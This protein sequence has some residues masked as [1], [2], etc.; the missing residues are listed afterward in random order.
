MKT[1]IITVLIVCTTVVLSGCAMYER[2]VTKVKGWVGLD[3]YTVTVTNVTSNVYLTQIL[4]VGHE[5]ESYDI[6]AI[7]NPASVELQ[8]AAE[9][10]DI[11][12]ISAM[13]S[14][15]ADIVIDP[16]EGLLGPGESVE[17][18]IDGDATHLSLVAMIL[19]TNDGFIAL[20]AVD[21]R[22]GEFEL[23]ALDAGT[24]G[25]DEAITGGGAPNTPGIPA[26]PSGKADTSAPGI[27]GVVAEETVSRH[28]GIKGGEGS[29]LS[30]ENHGWSGPVAIVAIAS[31]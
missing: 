26:D 19:P 4:A 21:I 23:E 3:D 5:G 17:F 18:E 31:D 2:S 7:G 27:A 6:Y 8:A 12:G 13:F 10:G 24:E 20:D 22:P 14:K 16:A 15:K 9:G 1:K 28:R 30:Q 11:G 25:N 29:A